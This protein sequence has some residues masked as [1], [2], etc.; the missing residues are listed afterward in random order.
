VA[1]DD[2]LMGAVAADI[3]RVIAT[4]YDVAGDVTCEFLRHGFNDHF[5]AHDAERPFHARLYL[6]GKYYIGGDADLRYELTLLRH[7]AAAGCPVANVL[8][9][10]DGAL[11]TIAEVGGRPR[12]LAV[13]AIAPGEV[14]P[15]PDADLA[16]DVGAAI[17]QL[18][19]AADSAPLPF[20]RYHLDER[21]VL[22]QP[23]DQ[24]ARIGDDAEA[25]AAIA[26]LTDRLASVLA[27]IPKRSPDY[28]LIHADLHLGNMHFDGRAFTLFD[29]DH[30]GV[31]WRAYDL[32]P[33]RMAADDARWER[34][35]AGYAS[36]RPLPE[37]L[38]RIDDFV[39]MRRLWDVG[40][41]L[42][43]EATWG[44]TR[45]SDQYR[46]QV[47]DFAVSLGALPG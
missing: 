35:L 37:G 44:T 39:T 6:D 46:P 15:E 4:E 12:R 30:C 31:G 10:R 3:G 38:D 33:L 14:N 25:V 8:P 24:L 43:M 26:A 47:R 13:F 7:L 20:E 29:F 5:R 9:R 41:V 1:D 28:G 22:D 18:H 23:R 19:A 34:L 16:E 45:F 21:I 11:L 36:V 17:A 32:A 2:A 40:D 42:A 27:T